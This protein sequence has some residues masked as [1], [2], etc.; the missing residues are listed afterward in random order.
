MVTAQYAP[1]ASLDLKNIGFLFLVL[2]RN[3]I[4]NDECSS[5]VGESVF[6]NVYHL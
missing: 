5:N 3:T 1:E 4:E 6:V 2:S